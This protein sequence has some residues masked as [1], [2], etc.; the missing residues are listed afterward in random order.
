MTHVGWHADSLFFAE[1][2]GFLKAVIPRRK[3]QIGKNRVHFC[4]LYPVL[5]TALRP[6]DAAQFDR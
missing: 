5:V 1:N 3:P 2:T 6:L 4:D